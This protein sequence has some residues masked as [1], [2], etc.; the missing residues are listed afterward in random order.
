MWQDRSSTLLWSTDEALILLPF[1]NAFADHGKRVGFKIQ[2]LDSVLR[3]EFEFL[4]AL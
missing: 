2:S 1:H 3:V 4:K